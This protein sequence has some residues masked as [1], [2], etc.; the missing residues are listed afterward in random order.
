MSENINL[1]ENIDN[2]EKKLTFHK[3]DVFVMPSII[4]GFGYVYLEAFSYGLFC[5]GTKNTALKD[6]SSNKTSRILESGD[7]ENLSL[8]LKELQDIVLTKGI[9]R[10]MIKSSIKSYTWEN[11]RQKVSETCKKVLF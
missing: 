11:Y 2:N 9:D 10:E 7:I 3:N 4:E 1:L 8:I 6:I 5:I